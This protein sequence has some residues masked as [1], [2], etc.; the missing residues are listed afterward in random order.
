MFLPQC[1]S[2]FTGISPDTGDKE[3]GTCA[4]VIAAA[5]VTSRSEKHAWVLAWVAS[6]F[7]TSSCA[8]RFRHRSAVFLDKVLHK[9]EVLVVV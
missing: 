9:S 2:S 3:W 6:R 7:V 8:L 1:N 4:Y 5:A